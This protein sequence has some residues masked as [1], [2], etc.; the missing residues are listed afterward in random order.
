MGVDLEDLLSA[1]LP[2]LGIINALRKP[3]PSF[4]GFWHVEYDLAEQG[5]R[6]LLV[7]SFC[8]SDTF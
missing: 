7:P 8:C 5:A 4:F 1:E 3:P 6:P 2:L